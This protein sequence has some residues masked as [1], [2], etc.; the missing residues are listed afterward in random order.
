MGTCYLSFFV[1]KNIINKLKL[2]NTIHRSYIFPINFSTILLNIS[3]FPSKCWVR[4]LE[5]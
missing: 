5:Q 3:S 1:Y 2:I 4:E